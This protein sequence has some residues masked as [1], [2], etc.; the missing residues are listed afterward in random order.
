MYT[1]RRVEYMYRQR[2]VS[3]KSIL[4]VKKF[5]YQARVYQ[6]LCHAYIRIIWPDYILDYTVIS[7]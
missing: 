7:K 5:T 1:G 4:A 3:K 6:L 2:V